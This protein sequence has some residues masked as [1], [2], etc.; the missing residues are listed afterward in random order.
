MQTF[1]QKLNK[2]IIGEIMEL[3]SSGFSLSGVSNRLP[4]ER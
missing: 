3:I 2:C 4:A 1:G